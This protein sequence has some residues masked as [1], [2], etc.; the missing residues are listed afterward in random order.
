[1]NILALAAIVTIL[2]AVG[3]CALKTNEIREQGKQKA[4]ADAEML[5]AGLDPFAERK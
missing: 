4:D 3:A 2:S 5:K 1:M